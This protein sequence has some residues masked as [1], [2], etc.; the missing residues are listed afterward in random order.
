MNV[1]ALYIFG[2]ILMYFFFIARVYFPFR[3]TP[4]LRVSPS[5]LKYITFSIIIMYTIE[6]IC[7]PIFVLSGLRY[8]SSPI[9]VADCSFR[10]GYDKISFLIMVLVVFGEFV[11]SVILLTLFVGRLYQVCE[12]EREREVFFVCYVA[13]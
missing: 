5:L 7:L 2:K 12:R 10:E 6:I 4:L 3:K 13:C 8:H 11:F 1:A 9:G